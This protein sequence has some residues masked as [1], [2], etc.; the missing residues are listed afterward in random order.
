MALQ[1]V[2]QHRKWLSGKDVHGRIYIS[3]Q[4]INAQLSGPSEDAE[5]Y[6]KWTQERQGWQVCSPKS[7][8]TSGRGCPLPEYCS[9]ACDAAFALPGQALHASTA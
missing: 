4:G 2:A 6:A 3:T 5:G 7:A 1:E 8:C 9:K